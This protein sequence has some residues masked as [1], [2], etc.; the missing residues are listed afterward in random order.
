MIANITNMNPYSYHVSSSGASG[1]L[2]VPVN[3]SA[4]IYAQFNHISGIAAPK[5]QNGV[6]ISKIQILNSLIENLTRIKGAQNS[7]K[8]SVKITQEQADALI[9]NYQKQIAQAV[10]ASQAQF[11]LNGA[12]PEAG[13]LF[14]VKA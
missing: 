2:F 5:G 9:K 13:A 8:K 10:Q 1:K 7:P 6:S 3:P 12:M 14:S 11:M 4:V